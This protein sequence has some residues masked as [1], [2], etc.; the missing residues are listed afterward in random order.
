ML[1]VILAALRSVHGKKKIQTQVSSFY[2]SLEFS[3][4]YQGMMIALPPT[5]WKIFQQLS[6]AQ[7]LSFL[8]EMAANVDLQK[9]K[10][11]TRGLKKVSKKRK[12]NK[13]HPHVAT[14]RLL[15]PQ[16]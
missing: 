4:V 2:L 6:P 3:G 15:N 5:K 11:H 13:R 12:Y 14:G 9:L 7:L 1:S 10:K 16:P 8:K